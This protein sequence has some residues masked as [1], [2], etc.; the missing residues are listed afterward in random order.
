MGLE[1]NGDGKCVFHEE[2]EEADASF[3][4][5]LVASGADGVDDDI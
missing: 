5:V 4:V 3:S 1:G 2:G